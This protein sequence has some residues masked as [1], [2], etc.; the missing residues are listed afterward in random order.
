MTTTQRT[1]H[2]QEH[3]TFVNPEALLI[4]FHN[5]IIH[6][7]RN[8]DDVLQRESCPFDSLE[9]I[10]YVPHLKMARGKQK[11]LLSQAVSLEPVNGVAQNPYV[12][13]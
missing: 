6:L 5:V 3:F 2:Q 10:I 9:A 13:I 4:G 11:Y 12:R 1:T 8:P 7:N